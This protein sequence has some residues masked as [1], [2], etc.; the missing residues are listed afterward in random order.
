MQSYGLQKEFRQVNL[1]KTEERKKYYS[2]NNYTQNP[3]QSEVAVVDDLFYKHTIK[4]MAIRKVNKSLCGLLI[5][6]ILSA[7]ISYYFVI[8][9]EV[10]LHKLNRQIISLNDENFELQNRLD[11]LKSFNNVDSKI[12]QSNILQKAENVIEVQEVQI[13]VVVSNTRIA[14]AP[15]RWAIGY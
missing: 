4:D 6:A 13:P 3:I 9:N 8:A 5:F 12:K 7:I 1:L 15:F 14:T 2:G 10:T 11:K